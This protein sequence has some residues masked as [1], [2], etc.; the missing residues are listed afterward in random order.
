MNMYSEWFGKSVPVT[1]D[2]PVEPG[3]ERGV[4]VVSDFLNRLDYRDISAAGSVVNAVRGHKIWNL[5]NIGDPRRNFH[6]TEVSVTP[7][8]I[9]VRTTIDTWFGLGTEHDKAVFVSEIKML[10]SFLQAGELSFAPLQEAQTRQR[11]SNLKTFLI[12]VGVGI[13]VGVCAIAVMNLMNR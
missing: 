10:S 8:M 3:T 7:D 2:I 4:D 12:L 9:R 1:A 13:L 6:S 5:I 11:K